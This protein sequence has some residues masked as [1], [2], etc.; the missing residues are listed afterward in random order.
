M[1]LRDCSIAY[2]NQA[3]SEADAAFDFAKM[4]I[5]F[6]PIP[7]TAATN[8]VDGEVEGCGSR[9]LLS[10]PHDVHSYRHISERREHPSMRGPMEIQVAFANPKRDHMDAVDAF[11]GVQLANQ[12]GESLVQ[13]CRDET[14]WRAVAVVHD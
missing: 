10:P 13:R 14:G 9:Y 5:R 2:L 7:A 8:K 4:R 12:I 11:P 6:D 1:R 3:S